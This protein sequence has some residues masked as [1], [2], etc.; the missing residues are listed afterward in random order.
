MLHSWIHVYKEAWEAAVEEELDCE[1][2]PNN[3]YD[4]CAVAAKR[5]VVVIHVP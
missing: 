3:A 4:G 5:K 2:E 1:R